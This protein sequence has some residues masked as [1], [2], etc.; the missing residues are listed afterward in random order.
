LQGKYDFSFS[1]L[2]TAVLRAVQRE[3]GVD[4]AFPSFKLA[5]KLSEKQKNDCDKPKKFGGG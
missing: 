1:G 4:F 5:E 2:K 3:V